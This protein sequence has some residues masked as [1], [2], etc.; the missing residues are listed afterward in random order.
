MA[1]R[2]KPRP[3]AEPAAGEGQQLSLLQHLGPDETARARERA[4]L[5]VMHGWGAA[6]PEIG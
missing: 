1:R 2:R 3:P 4:A 6:W 5:L